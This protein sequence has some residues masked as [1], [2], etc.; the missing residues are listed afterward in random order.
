MLYVD[1]DEV[2]DL[3]LIPEPNERKVK[4]NYLKVN[5]LLA[6]THLLLV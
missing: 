3:C 2:P 5:V 6:S 1:K 4:F